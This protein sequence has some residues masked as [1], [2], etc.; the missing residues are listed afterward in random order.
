MLTL[1][2]EKLTEPVPIKQTQSLPV[3]GIAQYIFILRFLLA[4]DLKREV[5]WKE[6]WTCY[7]KSCHSLAVKLWAGYFVSL[8]L[9]FLNF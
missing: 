9:R 8:N 5:A 1:T 6:P 7:Q 3:T 2:T 4:P